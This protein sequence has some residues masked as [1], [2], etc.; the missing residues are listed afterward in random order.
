MFSTKIVLTLVWSRIL[1]H[2]QYLV[3]F[4]K[5]LWVRKVLT[6]VNELHAVESKNGAQAHN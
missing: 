4:V 6:L 3:N 5:D 1:G 2:I